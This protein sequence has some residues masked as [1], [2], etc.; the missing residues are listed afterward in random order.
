MEQR[1]GWKFTVLTGGPC[2][3]LNGDIRTIAVHTGENAHGLSFAKSLPNYKETF[4]V[5]FSSF[6]HSVFREFFYNYSLDFINKC[7]FS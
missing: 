2:P 3:T 4:L 5:P 6:L 7:I 1:T